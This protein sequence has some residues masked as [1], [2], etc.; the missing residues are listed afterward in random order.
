MTDYTECI[1]HLFQRSSKVAM[2]RN[3]DAIQLLDQGLGYPSE[4]YR[5]IH[6]AGS[7]GK[8]SVSLKI[9]TALKQRG[10]G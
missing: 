7:N 1:E 5:T 8:G 4:C 3:L 2:H 10:I 9:A 6:V